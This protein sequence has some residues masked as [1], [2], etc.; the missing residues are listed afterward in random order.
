MFFFCGYFGIV[1]YV[2]GCC[3]MVSIFFIVSCG[4]RRCGFVIWSY[5]GCYGV[6]Y[7]RVGVIK[8][9][10]VCLYEGEKDFLKVVCFCCVDCWFIFIYCF[11]ILYK[12]YGK[13]IYNLIV[14]EFRCDVVECLVGYSGVDRL[15]GVV[16]LYRYGIWSFLLWFNLSIWFLVVFCVFF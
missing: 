8:E 6:G 7:R 4:L 13:I 3:E 16:D 9:W 15:D 11:L 2:V 1:D 10:W 12:F 14:E 5:I